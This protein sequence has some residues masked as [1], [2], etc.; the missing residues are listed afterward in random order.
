MLPPEVTC[1]MIQAG[2]PSSYCFLMV[3]M[4]GGQLPR[5]EGGKEAEACNVV[6]RGEK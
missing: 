1:S 4:E 3:T 6:V 5:G 2:L